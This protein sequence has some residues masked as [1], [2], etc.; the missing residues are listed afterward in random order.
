MQ[1][2]GDPVVIGAHPQ[3]LGA[4]KPSFQGV[5]WDDECAKPSCLIR[6]CGS[7][8]VNINNSTISGVHYPRVFGVPRAVVCGVDSTLVVLRNSSIRRNGASE[9]LAAYQAQLHVLGSTL[10]DNTAYGT[11]GGLVAMQNSIVV[12][13]GGSAITGNEAFYVSG[14][15]VAVANSAVFV[16]SGGSRIVNNTSANLVGGGLFVMGNGQAHIEGQSI[17]CNNTSLGAAGGGGIGVVEQ[18]QLVVVTGSEVCNNRGGLGAGGI[19]V[20]GDAHM[21]VRNAR[22]INNFAAGSGGGVGVVGNGY[23]A[24]FDSVIA[25]NTCLGINQTYGGGAIVAG[26][27]ATVLLFD[28]TRLVSNKAVGLPGGAFALTGN[29]STTIAAGVVLLD[30]SVVSSAKTQLSVPFGLVGVT[31]WT[32]KLDIQPGVLGDGAPLTKCNRSIALGR[33]P[34]GIGEYDSGWPSACLCC[35]V[36]T[37]SFESNVTVCQQ[38]PA[39]ADCSADIVSP[40][41]GYW[42]SSPRSLQIHR[43]PI[44]GV[45]QH[46]GVCVSGYTGNLCG[47]C[48]DGY[49]T[50]APLRC[51]QCMSPRLQLGVYGALVGGTVL[52]VTTTVHFT[53]QDNKAGDKSLRPSDLIK[54]LVQFLQYTVILGSISIP[55]PAF[56]KGMFT[57]ATAVFGVGSGQ[58]LSLD[59]WLPYY[60]SS[61]L[62]VA[63]QRQL[64]YFVGALVVA[65]ACVVLMNLLHVC[66][67]ML[68]AC[69]SK[70]TRGG[71][72]QQ[73]PKLHFWSRLR[74]TLLV[75]AF[76]AYPTLVKGALSFFACLR[77]DDPDSKQPYPEYSIRSHAAGYFVSAIEQEC[78]AGW[79]R[80]WAL[81][82]G[83][84]AVLVLCLGVPVGLW[85]FLWRSKT[86]TSDAAFREHYGF[87]FRNYKESRPWWEAVWSVQTV[88]LTAISVFHFTIQAYYALMLMELVLLLSVAAQ[89]TARPYAQPL[90]H[91]LHLASTCC[92]FFLVW[93][94]LTLFSASVVPDSIAVGRANTA[95]GAVMIVVACAFVLCCLGMIVR[96]ASPVLGDCV[97]STAAWL[98]ACTGGVAS[99]HQ[100]KSPKQSGQQSGRS[101][102]QAGHGHQQAAGGV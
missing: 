33:R 96:L 47:Q 6:F 26:D 32:S 12:V 98:R 11:S 31:G 7:T 56:V 41:E 90:L 35:P 83:L 62:P 70:P 19:F 42:H 51:G 37:Y 74:V 40:V 63:L 73:A 101:Q 61:K 30:N 38:C 49:G 64:S 43:C 23:V 8:S 76:Y 97:S 55:W 88:L 69:M 25:N 13:A 75:T 71:R 67:R 50:T 15:G 48:A 95:V 27:N 34:C 89:V 79:H 59:C 14:A 45:C 52:F 99:C 39:N 58:A 28:G 93:L 68:K 20:S 44:V 65:V 46:G 91:R 80:A 60:V 77:I 9:V 94:S 36:F 82:F 22:I 57:A 84:P 16:L 2:S 53:W 81:G 4:F 78:Y 21:I 29:A 54:V 66:N 18:A 24:V 92:L 87:L 5:V 10:S 102:S 72:Q 85:L 86:K 100:L 1:C 17:V 3:L